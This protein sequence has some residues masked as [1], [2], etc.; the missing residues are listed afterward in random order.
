MATLPLFRNLK[1]GSHFLNKIKQ[2]SI[3]KSSGLI[4]T[5][6][7]DSAQH[8]YAKRGFK[9]ILDPDQTDQVLM[10]KL[11]KRPANT[12]LMRFTPNDHTEIQPITDEIVTLYDRLVK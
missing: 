3:E 10:K 8:W 2:I 1:S 5:Y 4:Y 6:A 7:A 11:S 9:R 12:V